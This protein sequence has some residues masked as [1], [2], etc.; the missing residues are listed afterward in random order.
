VATMVERSGLSAATVGQA[1]RELRSVGAIIGTERPGRT[2]MYFLP[3]DDPTVDPFA[4]EPPPNFV[5]P[6]EF[7]PPPPQTLTPL[8]PQSLG[9]DL[10]PLN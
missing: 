7:D 5:P 10:Y 3:M 9:G 8:P 6:Q 1:L 2:T 4:E